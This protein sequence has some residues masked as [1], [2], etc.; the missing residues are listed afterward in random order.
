MTTYAEFVTAVA[1]LSITGVNRQYTKEI[2]A[3]HTADLPV[4]FPRLPQGG[5]NEETMTTCTDDGKTRSIELVILLEPVGQSTTP[6]NFDATVAMA[7]N[8]ESAIDTAGNTIMPFVTYDIAMNNTAVPGYWA[9]I[10][11]VT[12]VE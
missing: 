10:A 12:G 8:V 11:T 7:D 9:V 6:A 5:T 4:S 1:G 3:A 2:D